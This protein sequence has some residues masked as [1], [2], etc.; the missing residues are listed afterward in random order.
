[1]KS[2]NYYMKCYYSITGKLLAVLKLLLLFV[3]LTPIGAQAAEV[4]AQMEEANDYWYGGR[5]SEA[6]RLYTELAE[7]GDQRAMYKLSD[8][9][10][11]NPYSEKNALADPLKAFYWLER[12]ATSEYDRA[13]AHLI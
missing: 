9:F 13:Q 7:S 1:V 3:C 10:S 4:S 2:K 8:I 5:E 6:I 11:Q 12:A